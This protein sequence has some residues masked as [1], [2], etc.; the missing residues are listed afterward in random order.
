[1]ICVW[2]AAQLAMYETS[3]IVKHKLRFSTAGAKPLYRSLILLKVKFYH[4][5]TP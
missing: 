4:S 5:S 3:S 2:Y 1:M